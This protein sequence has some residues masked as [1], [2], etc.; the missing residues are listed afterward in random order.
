MTSPLS[1]VP[2]ASHARVLVTTSQGDEGKLISL[3]SKGERAWERALQLGPGPF[4]LLALDRATLVVSRSGGAVCV[5]SDGRIAWRVGAAGDPLSGTVEP[6]R[7]RGLLWIAG[8]MVR[9]VDPATGAVVGE[10]SAGPGLCSLALDARLN[11]YLLGDEGTLRAY[12]LGTHLS[13][14]ERGK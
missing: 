14:V 10:V 12:R 9:A 4:A 8:Q 13:V 11:L 5:E 3:T 1:S 2:L 6:R 7:S